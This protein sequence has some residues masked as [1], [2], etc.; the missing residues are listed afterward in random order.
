MHMLLIHLAHLQLHFAGNLQGSFLDLHQF[1][2]GEGRTGQEGVTSAPVATSTPRLIA[3]PTPGAQA[4]KK[5][6]R[7]SKAVAHGTSPENKET[8]AN[9]RP[10]T[11]TPQA[12]AELSRAKKKRALN[13]LIPSE[14]EWLGRLDY[15]EVYKPF[16]SHLFAAP[17]LVHS[18]YSYGA[19]H[20]LSPANNKAAIGCLY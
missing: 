6:A 5:K 19:E 15:S 13:I 9:P 14:S 10:V 7:Q 18:I 8:W 20:L 16:W 12:S 11:H 3:A 1:C 2:D 17:A 4:L